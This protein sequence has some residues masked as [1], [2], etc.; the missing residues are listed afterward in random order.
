VRMVHC[1]WRW[2]NNSATR[3]RETILVAAWV[4]LQQG[5]LD[6]GDAIVF[7]ISVA[8]VGDQIGYWVGREEGRSVILRWA[9]GVRW[10]SGTPTTAHV[11]V[12][13]LAP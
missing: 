5:H 10:T 6:L 1:R 7:G 9:V 8:M 4:M 12:H 11:S 3:C 2:V 13:P